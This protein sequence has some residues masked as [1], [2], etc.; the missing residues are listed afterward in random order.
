VLLLENAV[1]YLSSYETLLDMT[2]S[3][4][5]I[6]RKNFVDKFLRYNISSQT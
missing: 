4:F 3:P 6:L 5:Q 2:F 1:S